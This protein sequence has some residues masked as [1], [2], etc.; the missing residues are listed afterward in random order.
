MGRDGNSGKVLEL[1]EL[2]V[3]TLP[4][5]IKEAAQLVEADLH[6]A[7]VEARLPGN[8]PAQ[9]DSLGT[10]NRGLGSSAQGW[11]KPCSEECCARPSD[12]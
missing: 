6:S 1:L 5:K 10:E 4:S 3:G 11:E 9:V 7:V 12:R 8:T 2:K